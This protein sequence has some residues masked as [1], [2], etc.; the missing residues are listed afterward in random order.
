[1]LVIYGDLHIEQ[2]G[3]LLGVFEVEIEVPRD[4]PRSAMPVV[5]EVGGR[6]P[7]YR[8]RHVN[9]H[10]GSACLETPFAYWWRNPNGLDL[11]DFIDGPVWS[12]YFG[13][14][15]VEVGE[16]WPAGE[17]EHESAGIQ[18]AYYEILQLRGRA[19]LSALV[20]LYQTGQIRSGWRCPCGSGARSGGCHGPTL[21][22]IGRRVPREVLRQDAALINELVTGKE[23]S[24]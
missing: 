3:A 8:D 6:I 21:N 16:P 20:K 15:L 17:W 2:A 4:G 14:S 7:P 13:Q 24:P 23:G 19:L 12:Y 22:E 10:D 5:R 1:M 11:P 18:D 9:E